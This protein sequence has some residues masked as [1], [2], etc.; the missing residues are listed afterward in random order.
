MKR[1]VLAI[2]ATLCAT[3]AIPLPSQAQPAKAS[4]TVDLVSGQPTVV[5]HV[6]NRSTVELEAWEVRIEYDLGSGVRNSL[7]VTTDGG[8][9]PPP[10]GAT[11]RGPIQPGATRHETIAL[12]GIPRTAS[13]RMVTLLFADFSWEGNEDEVRHV[14]AQRE[15]R[16]ATLS[17]WIG[18]LQSVSSRLPAQA[19]AALR[20][21]VRSDSRFTPDES[22]SWA[23]AVRIH[24]DELV[25]AAISD[26]VFSG[27]IAE[28]TQRFESQRTLALRHKRR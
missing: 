4:V 23:K 16:A 1:H 6:T 8:F 28:M 9:N 5:V 12:G 21:M 18:A 13:A 17:L 10:P 27:H 14:F 19:R 11:D 7:H 22:D 26:D 2:L 20:A 25:E 3:A 15:R 24:I